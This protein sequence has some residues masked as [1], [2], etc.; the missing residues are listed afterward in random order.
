[1]PGP[2]VAVAPQQTFVLANRQT[3]IVAQPFPIAQR[4]LF[5]PRGLAVPTT[6]IP[7]QAVH[8]RF[9]NVVVFIDPAA[10]L[11]WAEGFWWWNGVAWAW[12]GETLVW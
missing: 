1:M 10:S 7:C 12:V 6:F 5:V 9:G 2:T 4:A 3:V 8:R 11:M